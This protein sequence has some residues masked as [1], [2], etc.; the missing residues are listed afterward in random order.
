M[1]KSNVTSLIHKE[2]NKRGIINFRSGI[3]NLQKGNIQINRNNTLNEENKIG[4]IL[5]VPFLPNV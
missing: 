5:F 1:E 3:T 4:G 2:K